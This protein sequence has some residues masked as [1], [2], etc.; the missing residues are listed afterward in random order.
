MMNYP[1]LFRIINARNVLSSDDLSKAIKSIT[2]P[3]PNDEMIFEITSRIKRTS[4]IT[5]EQ[6]KPNK[7]K[8]KIDNRMNIATIKKELDDRKVTYDGLKR[9]DEL[10]KLLSEILDKEEENNNDNNE[11]EEMIDINTVHIILSDDLH[12]LPVEMLPVMKSEY[13]YRLPSL[14]FA[15]MVYKV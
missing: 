6:N 7:K 11:I 12:W 1:I 9:K 4:D 8:R 14:D 15:I 3:E 13:V 2:Y 5:T 10:L